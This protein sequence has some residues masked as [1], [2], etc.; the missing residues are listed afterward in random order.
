MSSHV[1][2]IYQISLALA[3]SAG[4]ECTTDGSAYTTITTI[5]GITTLWSWEVSFDTIEDNAVFA[6]KLGLPFCAPLRHRKVGLAYGACDGPKVEYAERISYVMDKQ[7]KNLRV[8]QQV[9]PR[10]HII[11]VPADL[12]SDC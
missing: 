9:D 3:L 12:A 11:E 6:Q 7:E 1:F 4:P 8:Y 10:I 5:M 2:V